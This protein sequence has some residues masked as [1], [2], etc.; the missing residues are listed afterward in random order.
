MRQ[1]FGDSCIRVLLSIALIATSGVAPRLTHAHSRG[2]KQHTHCAETVH[3][4]TDHAGRDGHAH[5]CPSGPAENKGADGHHD[6]VSDTVAHTHIACFGMPI[7]VPVSSDEHSTDG[8]RQL[9]LEV[10]IVATSSDV[11]Q[12]AS[13]LLAN[14]AVPLT[15]SGVVAMVSD[16]LASAHHSPHVD[17]VLLCDTAR[18]E[19]SGVLLV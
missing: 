13:R 1:S 5:H 6:C 11:L 16:D 12:S 19:R 18:L 2:N 15:A 7:T 4:L 8:P 17:R 9:A 14:I 10:K 3:L